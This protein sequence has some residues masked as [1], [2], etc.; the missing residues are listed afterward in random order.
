MF[1]VNYF[2][3]LFES[4]PEYRKIKLMMFLIE[5]DVDLFTECGY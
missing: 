3:D 1:H 2:E 4:I 5:N